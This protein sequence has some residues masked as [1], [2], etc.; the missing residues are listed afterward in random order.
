MDKR[1][2]TLFTT[3]F[4]FLTVII[5][6]PEAEAAGYDA[7]GVDFRNDA[8]GYGGAEICGIGYPCGKADGVCP[9]NF[10]RGYNETSKDFYK[11][12]FV[13]YA[14]PSSRNVND[15]ST[16]QVIAYEDGDAAC[17]R[18]GGTCQEILESNSKTGS[19]TP[20]SVNCGDVSGFDDARYYRANCTGVPKV[21]GCENCPDPDCE[22]N[23][24]GYV[25]DT[26]DESLENA[27][28][29]LT[30]DNNPLL[31]SD[32]LFTRTN[33]TGGFT[34]P[35]AV[36]GYMTVTCGK[37]LYSNQQFQTYVQP[38]Q[39]TVTCP[40]LGAAACSAN[41][42]APDAFGNDVCV[43][44]CDG[45][46][47]CTM[48]TTYQD[49]CDGLPPDA[50]RFLERINDTHIR[51][52]QCCDGPSEIRYAPLAEIDSNNSDVESLEIT[53]YQRELNGTPVTV[54]VVRYTD[55]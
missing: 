52:G 43:A 1:V 28:V 26:D 25:A 9:Q 20:S 29:T 17:Q 19:Y 11:L 45:E 38:G 18:I 39:D 53:D 40:A 27:T 49:L 15:T 12:P 32:R 8:T 4:L 3:L 35:K 23:I 34:L 10:S 21:A 6:A 46:N 22:A 42:T 51:V 14:T 30:N 5:V 7:C 36:S 13:R 41:C 48:N 44:S 55:R 47:G 24:T 16:D 54:K 2:R 33:S 37:A 50:E 31:P